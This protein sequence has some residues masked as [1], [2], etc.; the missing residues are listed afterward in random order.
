MCQRVFVS[1]RTLKSHIAQIHDK[2]PKDSTKRPRGHQV[3]VP[4]WNKG[5]TKETSPIILEQSIQQSYR[6]KKEYLSGKRVPSVQT[7]KA[8][9]SL[10]ERM[11]LH[12]PGGR[13]KWFSVSGRMVQGTYEKQFAE[14]CDEENI[15]WEKVSTNNHVSNTVDMV[16]LGHTLQIFICRISAFMLK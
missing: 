3:S 14:R 5:L 4:A 8:K 2:K 9:Q 6:Q 13:S 7:E 10:S 11:S 1:N 12:N 15:L 16:R